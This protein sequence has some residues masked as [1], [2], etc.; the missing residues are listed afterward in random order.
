MTISQC[1]LTSQPPCRNLNKQRN[2]LGPTCAVA[3]QKKGKKAFFHAVRYGHA[4]H[5]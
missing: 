3:P 1:L 2:G 4:T 5:S